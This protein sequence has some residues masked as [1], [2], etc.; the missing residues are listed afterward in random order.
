MPPPATARLSRSWMTR[1]CA[2]KS[3]IARSVAAPS[4]REVIVVPP[5]SIQYT[6]SSSTISL[7]SGKRCRKPSGP[8]VILGA[9]LAF[10]DQRLTAGAS[11]E[12][13]VLCEGQAILARHRRI[14]RLGAALGVLV[15][16]GGFF[17]D[18]ISLVRAEHDAVLDEVAFL[19][20]AQPAQILVLRDAV[21]Q[22]VRAFDVLL[23]LM[24]A[25]RL[26]PTLKLDAVDLD[27][28][29]RLLEAAA[30]DGL[31]VRHFVEN[32]QHDA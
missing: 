9:S 26:P 11:R 24:A 3:M 21:R 17:L 5:A 30:H 13:R 14:E 8:T 25:E 2:A 10:L 16:L 4:T 19:V 28:L 12:A 29:P 23:R 1:L 6:M 32:A 31:L 22:S 27:C 18:V 15:L 20:L 7:N